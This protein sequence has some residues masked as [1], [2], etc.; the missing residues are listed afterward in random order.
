M[1]MKKFL[2]VMAAVYLVAAVVGIALFKSP[3]HSKA[4]LDQYGHD[5]E[6]CEKI[7][8]N[9]AYKLYAERKHLYNASPELLAD[10]KF[11]EEF[12]AKPAFQA[13]KKRRFHYTMYFKALNSTAFILLIAF[14]AKKPL[15][16][17]L[18]K[19]IGE[20]QSGLEN[21]EQSKRD[22]VKAKAAAAA[23]MAQWDETAKQIRKETDA[24][25]TSQLRA[26]Q[27]ELEDAKAQLEKE[28]QDRRVAEELRAARII[29]EE[30][31]TQALDSLDRRYRSEGTQVLL[32][33]NVDSFVRF[34]E[35]LT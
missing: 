7:V 18:D 19:Q 14:A 33:A 21:A 34:M 16:E 28:E 9:D 20:I 26:I 3:N 32:A 27:Q 13:E 15:L 8:K 1:N 2:Y 31:V 22:A 35:R 5:L 4:F 30:L 12:E 10:A 6:R 11:V 17:F 25:I 29:K 23:K 24:L